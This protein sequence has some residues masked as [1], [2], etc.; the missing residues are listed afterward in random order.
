MRRQLSALDY[1]LFYRQVAE[2]DLACQ[3]CHQWP[4][5]RWKCINRSGGILD[6]HHLIPQQVLKRELPA[7][8][9]KTALTDPR[10][11]MLLGRYHHDRA[12]SRMRTLIAPAAAWEFAAE[13]GLT[14]ALER[15][16][17]REEP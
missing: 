11:G 10:N 13:L 12:E 4:E 6:A 17:L 16:C 9:L 5:E 1:G 14:Y 2:R 15:R 3:G 8:Q 7:D